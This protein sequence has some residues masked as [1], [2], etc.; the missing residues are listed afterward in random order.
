MIF[1]PGSLDVRKLGAALTRKD[2]IICTMRT[3][4]QAP[5]LRLAPHFYNTMD[6]MDRTVETIR[7]YLATG[8]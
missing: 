4:P 2:R 3:G 1:Q 8:V 6:E 5:G 7:R